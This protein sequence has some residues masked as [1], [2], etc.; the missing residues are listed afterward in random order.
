MKRE[1]EAGREKED[2]EGERQEETKVEGE[3][4]KTKRGNGETVKE[5][6]GGG[7]EGFVG[8]WNV[9]CVMLLWERGSKAMGEGKGERD[10]EMREGKGCVLLCSGWQLTYLRGEGRTGQDT[11]GKGRGGELR[12]IRGNLVSW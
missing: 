7:V 2:G 9:G 6:N 5:R 8:T 10:S 1:K 11:A 4:G 3:K 12:G